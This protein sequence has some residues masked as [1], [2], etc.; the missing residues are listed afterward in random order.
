MPS[1]LKDMKV[2]GGPAQ[3]VYL[4][5]GVPGGDDAPWL[6]SNVAV[7]STTIATQGNNTIIAAPAANKRI[8]VYTL[9]IQNESA[10]DTTVIVRD[11]DTHA[12]LARSTVVAPV[13]TEMHC[14][15]CH[16]NNG[17][18]NEGISSPTVEQNILKKHDQEEGTN[19]MGSRPVLCASC[20]SSNAI[21][22]PSTTS[23]RPSD[24]SRGSVIPMA[25]RPD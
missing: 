23:S 3:P 15:N 12:E 14:D 20:H 9:M 4:M 6:G 21:G 25:T 2:S 16:S 17:R 18:G 5:N 7:F 19:L 1:H 8:V 13:S 11:S 22:A 10:T 24:A